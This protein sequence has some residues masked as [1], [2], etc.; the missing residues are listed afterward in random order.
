MK[1]SLLALSFLLFAFPLAFSNDAQPVL[2]IAGKPVVSGVDYVI[3]VT[4][5]GQQ[6]A[7]Y[8]TLGKT[9]NST[10]PATVEVNFGRSAA[11]PVKFT[12]VGA[13]TREIFTDTPLQIEFPKNFASGVESPKW[14]AVVDTVIQQTYVGIGGPEDHPGQ[15]VYNG[16]FSILK[17]SND[18]YDL[19]F[20]LP[21]IVDGSP[22][23]WNIRFLFTERT[24]CLL[25]L[26][27]DE[28]DFGF[29]L[30][31]SEEYLGIR[32]VV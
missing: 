28:P 9:G 19:S 3:F 7:G 18:L 24:L 23:S 22:V 30:I 6:R 31:K 20:S 10:C 1:P 13:R 14:T 29:A 17:S 25:A 26:T 8:V 15:Q 27:N 32:T 5:S 12:P 16:A 4:R 11:I 21:V 2:D